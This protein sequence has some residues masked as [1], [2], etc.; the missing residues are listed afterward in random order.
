[1]ADVSALAVRAAAIGVSLTP[2]QLGQFARYTDLVFKWN[3]IANLI[4][5]MRPQEFIE[6]HLLDCLAV[7]PF[8]RGPRVVDVG[9]GAGLPGVVIAITCPD[10]EV[11]VVE[12][13][14]KRARFL[15]Q[16]RI[17]LGLSQLH[18]VHSRVEAWYSSQPVDTVI[19]RAFG[20]LADFLQA[21]VALHRAHGRLL[22]MKGRDPAAE[23]AEVDTETWEVRT[24]VLHVPTWQARHLVILDRRAG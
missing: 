14:G 2:A 6:R 24:E 4:G 11:S 18:V 23:L 12:P 22:A 7:V 9:S 8:L 3:R 10:L 15:E 21:T 1:M 5:T 17:E 16:V 19:C 13:R 20:R